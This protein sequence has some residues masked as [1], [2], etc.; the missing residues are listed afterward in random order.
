M[1]FRSEP[2]AAA[3][4][5]HVRRQLENEF[6]VDLS[7]GVLDVGKMLLEMVEPTSEEG[8]RAELDLAWQ[9]ILPTDVKGI[10]VDT[11]ARSTA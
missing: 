5:G 1:L 2:D 7:C 11:H 10:A 8:E 3:S 4:F 9:R 6:N